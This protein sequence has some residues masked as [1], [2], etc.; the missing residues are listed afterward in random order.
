MLDLG[1]H[2]SGVVLPVKAMPGSRTSQLRG[3]HNGALKVAVTQVAEKG[4]ANKA[5]AELLA[6]V[7]G[8]NKSDV[9]LLSGPTS[10]HKQFLIRGLT[11]DDVRGRLANRAG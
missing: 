5:I 9:Q 7:L 3:E 6:E 4:K 2:P 10:G 8:V 1:D 11:C